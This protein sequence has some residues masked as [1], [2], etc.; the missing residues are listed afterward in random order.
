MER[1]RRP[2]GH[3]PY[4]VE[5]RWFEVSDGKT[6]ECIER[7]KYRCAE[8]EDCNNQCK[9]PVI[10]NLRIARCYPY[11]S[12]EIWLSQKD[13]AFYEIVQTDDHQSPEF[14]SKKTVSRTLSVIR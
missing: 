1:K 7:I 3:Y 12:Q 6:F 9:K 11:R 10:R 8:E 13:D 4:I 2:A 5:T 14:S